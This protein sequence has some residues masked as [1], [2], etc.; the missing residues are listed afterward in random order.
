MCG[1]IKRCVKDI[2]YLLYSLNNN[3]TL[4]ELNLYFECI[5]NK[6]DFDD[7]MNDFIQLILNNKTLYKISINYNYINLK[8]FIDFKQYYL[9][10]KATDK[11]RKKLF[12]YKNI[13][14]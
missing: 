4:N 2:Q 10:K 5:Y 6:T 14:R 3:N 12:E 13:K 8:N 11:N 7:F 9:L 1:D